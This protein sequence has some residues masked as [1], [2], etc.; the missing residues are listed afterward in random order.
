VGDAFPFEAFDDQVG[1]EE[2]G[3]RHLWSSR[4]W[5]SGLPR[6]AVTRGRGRTYSFGFS[7]RPWSS[8]AVPG[9]IDQ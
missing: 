7:L 4:P 3:I 6:E 1:N 2:L 9:K 8:T 5:R